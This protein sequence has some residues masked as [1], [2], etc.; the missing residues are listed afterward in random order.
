MARS[1]TCRNAGV[2]A[3]RYAGVHHAGVQ[4]C[5]NAACNR[6]L[7]RTPARDMLRMTSSKAHARIAACGGCDARHCEN[8]A[9]CCAVSH[10]LRETRSSASTHSCEGTAQCRTKAAQALRPTALYWHLVGRA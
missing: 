6:Q 8:R 5:R 1:D 2:E 4:A 7:A 3:C 9:F 10:C